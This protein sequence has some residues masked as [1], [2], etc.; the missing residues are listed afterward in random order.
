MNTAPTHARLQ[1]MAQ[2]EKLDNPARTPPTPAA[3]TSSGRHAKPAAGYATKQ[4]AAE[5]RKKIE[6][7]R[8]LDE[9][10]QRWI[11]VI[12]AVALCFTIT[13]VT[14]F[15]IDHKIPWV[16]AWILD[17]VV[18]L[19]LVLVLYTDGRLAVM[20]PSYKPAGWSLALRYFAFLTTWL[21]NCWSSLFPD[22]VVRLVPSEADP[23]GLLLHSALPLLVFGL[24]EY[25][26]HNL[27]LTTS[28]ISELQV[29][30]DSHQEG[31]KVAEQEAKAKAEAEKE[32]EETLR[33]EAE[34]REKADAEEKRQ[35]ERDEENARRAKV[36]AERELDL[37][38]KQIEAE[39]EA[40]RVKAEADAARIKAENEAK[41]E[42]ERVRYELERQEKD[43][44][45]RRAADQQRAEAER[46]K[47]EAD[48]ARIKAEAEAARIKAENEAKIEAERVRYELE[49]QEKDDETRRA[50]DQQ[51]AEA[52][53]ERIK[54]EADAE[55]IKA[56]A[57]AARQRK[58]AEVA[59]KASAT[60]APSAAKT[61]APAKSSTSSSGDRDEETA[62][63]AHN[64]VVEMSREERRALQEDAIREAA[65]EIVMYGGKAQLPYTTEEFGARYGRKDRWGGLRI[66]DADTRLA[67]DP[68]YR[69]EIERAALAR[70]EEREQTQEPEASNA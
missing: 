44:E 11:L 16:I 28:R 35:A 4:E 55:R 27:K 61:S 5:A 8:K 51:R 1:A 7:L 66:T 49:R 43:D 19:A 46:I 36:A 26:S 45:T 59:A 68:A 24:A 42:A 22:K 41:I 53:A 64:R 50:A 37:K 6:H 9:R 67:G 3:P 65:I 12:G 13:N 63:A 54:A 29:I 40:E 32:K 34:E 33:Q 30:V 10:N 57:E 58:L 39:A 20:I 62:R 23:A 69:E 48:A 60:K 47:A 2:L 14:I 38:R 21:M 56:E 17:L 70:L 15:A 18:N 25:S 52:E 31:I